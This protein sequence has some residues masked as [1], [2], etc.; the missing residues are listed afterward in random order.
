MPA[1]QTPA[2]NLK[3][4][5][6]ETGIAA[7][8]LRAWERRYGLPKPQR[9]AGGHRLYS[10]HD[11]GLIKWLLARQSEGLS[12]SRAVDLW[13][14]TSASGQDPLDRLAPMEEAPLPAP[15][16]LETLRA[17]WLAACLAYD[18]MR[19]GEVLNRA[20]AMYPVENVV[21]SL[22][23]AGL[24]EI[25]AMWHRGQASV[26]QE[27]FASALATRHLDALI[28]AAPAPTRRETLLLA[29][30]P[31]EL[32]AFPLL[33]LSLLLRR[34]GWRVVYLGA[35]VPLAHLSE[36]IQTVG[37]DLVILA[38]QGLVSAAALRET[39]EALAGMPIRLAYGGG[40][41]N[42]LPA[43]GGLIPGH[44]IAGSLE[45]APGRVEALLAEGVN[46]VL[47]E[48]IDQTLARAF[49]HSHPQI[50]SVLRGNLAASGLEG[51]NLVSAAFLLGRSLQAAL[52]LGDVGY[53]RSD[54][55]WLQSLSLG[56]DRPVE[57][58]RLFISAYAAAVRQVM[59][60]AG[61]SIAGWLDG[62]GSGI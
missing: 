18:E 41:F 36:T 8:T 29:C 49:H 42:R 27:H 56:D 48:V 14:E 62:Y 58:L 7:D 6:K 23:Q 47:P 57:S 37:P 33:I 39:A 3:V 61:E 15:E 26:Q 40:I 59:G 28:S 38:A 34:R 20:F 17:E 60:A 12:I 22:I 31:G 24:S 2:Y 46:P 32:H 9:T 19:A 35:D 44:L 50:D 10:Q 13:R 51:P 1:S 54:L 30:P 25:G 21:I 11:I 55:D 52:Q 45:D 43:L 16:S 5:L 53:L 4:V